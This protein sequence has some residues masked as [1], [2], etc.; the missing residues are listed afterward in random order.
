MYS[1]FRCS[2]PP[3]S[4]VYFV[5]TD[6]AVII[7]TGHPDFAEQTLDILKHHI[8][9]DNVGYILCTHAH[10]DHIGSAS[11]FQ[12]AC[13]AKTM[14][15][16]PEANSKLTDTH[17]REI[18]LIYEMPEIDSYLEPDMEITLGD[19]II[20][21]LHTPGHADEHC[22]FYFTKRRFLFTG[23]ILAHEDIGFLNLNKHYTI[24]LNEIKHSVE[25]C[26]ALETTRVFTGHGDPY[27]SAPWQKIMRKLSLFEKNPMLL[28]PHALISPFLFHLWAAGKPE[29]VSVTEAY[30]TDHAYLFDGFLDNCTPDL[31]LQEFRKLSTLLA[32]RGVV[33]VIDNCYIHTYRNNLT[34]HYHR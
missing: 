20:R 33:K 34:W 25:R 13:R 18:R 12:K 28:I 19:D 5:N 10:G 22:C 17:K 15:F 23:D 7:D 26:A 31:I 6:P 16:R 30:I 27:R 14:L 2:S 4:N 11:I 32:F 1:V 29:P 3:G 9:L 21:V 24:A 8:P